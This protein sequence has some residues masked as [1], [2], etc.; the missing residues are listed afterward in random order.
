MSA[1]ENKKTYL[2]LIDSQNHLDLN[3]IDE[4]LN[5]FYTPD[6]FMHF[7]GSEWGELDM[8]AMKK[9]SLQWFQEHTNSQ[10]TVD[11]IFAE[12]DR[13][14]TRG[15]STSTKAATGEPEKWFFLC[16]SRFSDGKVAEE[17]Q[18]VVQVPVEAKTAP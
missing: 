2:R 8:A 9:V 10:I 13:V 5:E 17:W 14:A 6:Y 15:L 7:P 12:G 1:E 16:L 3:D 11:D 4:F 18:L